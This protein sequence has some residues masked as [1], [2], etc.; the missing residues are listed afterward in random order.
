MANVKV[1]NPFSHFSFRIVAG[2]CIITSVQQWL[3]N[4]K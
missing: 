2:P 3:K 4:D 1:M